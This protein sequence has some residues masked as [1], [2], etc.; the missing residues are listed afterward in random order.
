MSTES[1]VKTENV[2]KKDRWIDRYVGWFIRW[3]PDSMALILLL[4][5]V[6]AIVIKFATGVPVLVS[7]ETQTSLLDSWIDGFWALLGF[8]MQMTLIMVTG[9]VVAN[10]RIVKK[11]LTRLASIPNSEVQAVLLCLLVSIALYWIH[12]G[13][14]T[15]SSIVIC[16][17]VL[18][19]ADK[20][21]YKIHAPLLIG[22]QVMITAY[23]NCGISQAAPLM[24]TTP[25]GLSAY[26][27]AE[28]ADQL[29]VIPMTETVLHPLVLGAIVV[30]F[31]VTL[32]LFFLLRPKR[33]EDYELADR[34]LL[35]EIEASAANIGSTLEGDG[36][37]TFAWWMNHSP[38]CSTIVAVA[39]LAW[40][41]RSLA[42]TGIVGMSINNFNLLMLMLGLL[43]SGSPANFARAV[44]ES[45]KNVWGVVIQFPLYAGLFGLITY[46][47]FSHI[48]TEFFLSIATA[49]TFPFIAYIYSGIINMMVPSGGSKFVIELPYILP[50]ALE[51]NVPLSKII[52]A[53]TWGDLTTNIIQPF[54]L[55]PLIACYK[56]KFSRLM[57]YGLIFCVIAILVHSFFFLVLY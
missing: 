30:L 6:L 20:K 43:L 12:W 50:T 32:A 55:L 16:Q 49:K 21:G 46:T 52:N 15:M 7:T 3:M 53:Y 48:I 31:G 33:A 34:A 2:S 39:G 37:K 27:P 41:A 4:T 42:E 22:T 57:P 28:Y 35:L 13:L 38:I 56:T 23:G 51:L 8:S 9:Y 18:L 5:I 24:A 1:K 44:T 47:G 19:Q 40:C 14:G 17:Q 25:G 11:G 10:A 45:M 26:V 36:K 29:D 54:W